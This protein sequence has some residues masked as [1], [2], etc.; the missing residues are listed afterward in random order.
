MN[1]F[2]KGKESLAPENAVN[3]KFISKE[4]EKLKSPR[5]SNRTTLNIH[6]ISSKEIIFYYYTVLLINLRS[7][8]IIS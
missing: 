6:N 4:T 8:S 2:K 1:R 7:T 3:I 5:N